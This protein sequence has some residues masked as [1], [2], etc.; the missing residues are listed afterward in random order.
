MLDELLTGLLPVLAEMDAA[1]ESECRGGKLLLGLGL[2]T[3]LDMP[4]SQ[5]R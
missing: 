3:L 2:R 1:R 5:G 4:H